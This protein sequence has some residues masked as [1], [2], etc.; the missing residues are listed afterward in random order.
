MATVRPFRGVTFDPTRVHD[1][2]DVTCP[3]YDVISPADRTELY[4]RDP[5]NIVRI[6]SGRDEDA[7]TE[8]DNKY[9]RAC[10]FFRS[11]IWEGVLREDTHPSLYVYRQAFTDPSGSIRR[12]SGLLGTI[13]LDDPILAHE[14]TMSGPKADRLALMRA[15]PANLSPIYALYSEEGGGV[16]AEL[17][18]RATDAPVADFVDGE[19]TRHTVWAVHDEAFHDK[20]GAALAELPL[21]IA[22]GHHR[23]ETSKLFRDERRAASGPGPYDSVMALLVDAAAQPVC[24]LPYH[25]I[26]RKA[27]TDAVLDVLHQSFDVTPLTGEPQ[28]LGL[29]LWDEERD[30]VFVAFVGSDAY[31]LEARD[32]GD[33]EIPAGVLK[34]LALEPLGAADAEGSLGFTPRADEVAAEVAAARAACGF[35]IQPVSVERVWKL[36]STGAKMP[37]KS[38]Y[39]HPKPRD[40]IVIRA[41]EPCARP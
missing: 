32:V 18:D 1:L 14:K 21:L 41:L 33:D 9:T 20:V 37:E 8:S 22:D 38:T 6:V 5:Y 2:A 12:V 34:R 4:E 15:V 31:R 7:D 35:L 36:A 39:F 17:P 3:P 24:I 26:V 30:G 11:F 13:S 40:G 19:Q 27:S 16:S 29:Q 28:K 23:F 10:G 25:R